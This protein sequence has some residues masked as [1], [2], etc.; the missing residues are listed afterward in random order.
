MGTVSEN[1]P[2]CS[3]CQEMDYPYCSV[4]K[5][6]VQGTPYRPDTNHLHS[7]SCLRVRPV[8]RTNIICGFD[9]DTTSKEDESKDLYYCAGRCGIST[10]NKDE[11]DDNG[12][13][14]CWHFECLPT[15]TQA[16]MRRVDDELR[17]K[18][19]DIV[20]RKGMAARIPEMLEL[21]LDDLMEFITQYGNKRDLDGRIDEY[22][23]HMPCTKYPQHYQVDKHH[24]E[25]RIAELK[26][27]QKKA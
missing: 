26:D 25:E 1:D 24:L 13:Y 27:K 22:T 23:N 5:D 20:T 19:K 18:L 16:E 21:E 17:P 9:N 11:L 7:S 6:E 3:Y 12:L 2:R 4:C 8:G 10:D 15:K 14:Y